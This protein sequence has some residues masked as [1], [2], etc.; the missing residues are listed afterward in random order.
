MGR[1][2][3]LFLV[4]VFF[5]S[6]SVVFYGFFDH[7]F[8][9]DII[10]WCAV[11]LFCAY[12][13]FKI[14][15]GGLVHYGYLDFLFA[16]FAVA[17][18]AGVLFSEY[19]YTAVDFLY[20]LLLYY[21]CFRFAVYIRHLGKTG[22]LVH[23]A[24]T[25]GLLISL[26]YGLYQMFFIIPGVFPDTPVFLIRIPSLPGNPIFFAS[27]ILISFPFSLCALVYVSKA[28][29]QKNRLLTGIL[30][31]ILILLSVFMFSMAMSRG[32][33]IALLFT[34]LYFLS[35]Y[36]GWNK[37]RKILPILICAVVLLGIMYLVTDEKAGS[38]HKERDYLNNITDISNRYYL[39]SG[40]LNMFASDP[41]FGKGPGSFFVFFPEYKDKG[42]EEQTKMQ[43]LSDHAHNEFLQVLSEAGI[44]GF[45]AFAILIFGVFIFS[46]LSPGK[47]AGPYLKYF[48]IC[49]SSAC[50]GIF[51]MML[52]SNV[53]NIAFLGA[54]FWFFAGMTAETGKALS[55]N[56]TL[57]KSLSCAIVLFLLFWASKYL[58]SKAHYNY[59]MR[60]AVNSD[61]AGN[62]SASVSYYD[63]ALRFAPE[64]NMALFYQAYGYFRLGKYEKAVGDY[65]KIKRRAPYFANINFGLGICYLRMADFVSSLKSFKDEIFINPYNPEAYFNAA[66]AAE[67]LGMSSESEAY[68]REA[69]FL[70]TDGLVKQEIIKIFS[71]KKRRIDTL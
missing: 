2:F 69:Y 27:Y 7:T 42:I 39:W 49:C 70:D 23:S 17:S 34:A 59:I 1:R 60:K 43:K 45:L 16:L 4:F 30:I 18:L 35:A 61:E 71:D 10:L 26:V 47:N 68:F 9:K 11:L 58:Y 53:Y 48:Y 36:F 65:L 14:R 31:L 62:Y 37:I 56:N 46:D 28:E 12:L 51:M 44:L 64:D 57:K 50:F 40:A 3:V 54:F 41:V 13:L 22:F 6:P 33:Q 67:N 25:L 63:E 66:I 32:S 21:L 8:I 15:A 19:R 38:L 52:F 29:K 55:L 24:F 5:V 20:K